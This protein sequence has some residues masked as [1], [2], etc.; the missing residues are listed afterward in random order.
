M[1]NREN[2][3]ILS[4]MPF[5]DKH[6]PGTFSWIENATSDQNAGK[7][8]YTSLF[9]WTAD[10]SQMGEG[11]YTMY[12]REGR[13]VAAAYA[14]SKTE[15]EAKVPPHWNLYISVENADATAARA[16]ELGATVLAPAFDVM[17]FG[18][19]AVIQDPTGA[20][21][22][23][24]QAK[25]HIGISVRDEFG[26]LC[27]ADVNTSDTA[28]AT[29]FYTGLFGWTTETSPDGYIHIKSGDKLIGGIVPLRD[30][31]T[32]PH[33]LVYFLVADCDASTA[34]AKGLGA[35][36]YAE[37][38]TMDKVGRI[39]VLA[40]PLGSVFALHQPVQH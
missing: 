15:R 40:D 38:F 13:T 17:T 18:R 33:W 7:S 9:G 30:P 21:F 2:S 24:W 39:A 28:K 6:T 37:P 1:Q 36:A 32:P 12:L 8:F 27:W 23:V 4:H 20:V 22:C 35:Q 34:K 19:M 16:A 31:K 11:A 14:L 10:D 25:T 3:D 26:S 29:A 5:F